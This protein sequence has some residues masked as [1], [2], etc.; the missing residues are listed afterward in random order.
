MGVDIDADRI[1]TELSLQGAISMTKGCYVGQEVVARTS[2][3]G[4]VRRQRVGFRF[5]WGGEPLPRRSEILVAGAPAGYVTSTA[6]E[7]GSGEGVGMGFLSTD[8][9][10][11]DPPIQV[12]Q[13]GRTVPVRIAA[14]PL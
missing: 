13:G 11:V 7:P 3:R 9:L 1:A 4:Q 10:S 12:V 5:K 6:R 14:W 8:A 2:N